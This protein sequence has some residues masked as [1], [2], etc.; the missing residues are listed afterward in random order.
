[1][2]S[3]KKRPDFFQSEEGAAVKAALVFMQTDELY[4]TESTYSANTAVYPDNKMTFVD[5]HMNYLSQHQSVDI[6][7]YLSNL[8]LMTRAR[9][10]KRF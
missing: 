9:V 5:R 10:S 7:Q 2:A 3:L 6:N 8:R 4:N 1:M